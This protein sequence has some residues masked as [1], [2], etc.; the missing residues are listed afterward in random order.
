MET[1]SRRRT[2][3]LFTD[4]EGS[5]RLLDEANAELEAG[6]VEGSRLTGDEA[7]EFVLAGRNRGVRESGTVS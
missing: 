3:L 6:I 5:T 4:V 2:T 1:Q 7:A